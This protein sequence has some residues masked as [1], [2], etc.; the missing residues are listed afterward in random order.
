[1]AVIAVV[2]DADADLPC[3]ESESLIGTP[4]VAAVAAPFRTSFTAEGSGVGTGCGSSCC[5]CFSCEWMSEGCGSETSVDLGAAE[6]DVRLDLG[7]CAGAGVDTSAGTGRSGIEVEER[8]GV[9]EG[10][11]IR[12]WGFLVLSVTRGG[13]SCVPFCG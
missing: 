13:K 7:L 8:T 12:F 5:S 11:S 10:G 3:R 1:M 6:S 4:D 2:A 9:G